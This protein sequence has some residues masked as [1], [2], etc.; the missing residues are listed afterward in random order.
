[1]K[2]PVPFHTKYPLL[3]LSAID[4]QL[5]GDVERMLLDFVMHAPM[6]I[7]YVYDK[8]ISM[9]PAILSKGFLGWSK[10]HRLL[11]R[12]HLW[13]HLAQDALNWIWAQ[14]TS[15]GFWDLGSKVSRR[16]YSSFPLSETWKRPENRIMDCS[17]EMLV[18][19]S[20]SF[21]GC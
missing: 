10:A 8:V 13:K 14:R 11:S 6:G 5:P 4:H 15:Q 19:L 18:L 12:F 3:I 21:D 16:P 2:N 1:M 20:R 9:Q 17:V 7:Y